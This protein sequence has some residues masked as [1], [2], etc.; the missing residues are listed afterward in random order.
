MKK[1][2]LFLEI[3]AIIGS[4]IM[5]GEEVDVTTKKIVDKFWPLLQYCDDKIK[6]NL[7]ANQRLKATIWLKEHRRHVYNMVFDINSGDGYPPTKEDR[8][9]PDL[10]KS[11]H[12]KWFLHN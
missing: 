3:E 12:W 10:W 6:P 2:K 8:N 4:G 9:N 7:N 1:E 5:N 11:E